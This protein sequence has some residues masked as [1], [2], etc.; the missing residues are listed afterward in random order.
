MEEA[1]KPCLVLLGYPQVR[2]GQ[3]ELKGRGGGNNGLFLPWSH[4]CPAEFAPLP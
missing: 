2:N 3:T 4:F 1:A